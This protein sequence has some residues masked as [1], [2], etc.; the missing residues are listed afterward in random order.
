[1]E[2]RKNHP[3]WI[4]FVMLVFAVLRPLMQ[5][6]VDSSGKRLPGPPAGGGPRVLAMMECR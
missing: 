4:G 1:M 2:S 3:G 6:G 5:A